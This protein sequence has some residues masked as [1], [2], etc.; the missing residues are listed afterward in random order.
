VQNETKKQEKRQKRTHMTGG[1]LTRIRKEMKFEPRHMYRTL[2]IPRRT[3]QDYEADKR[4]IPV[5]LALRIREMH[6]RD[7]EWVAGIG[8]RVDQNEESK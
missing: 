3:Y 8:D 2:N 4:G 1:E 6:K 5:K 7:R